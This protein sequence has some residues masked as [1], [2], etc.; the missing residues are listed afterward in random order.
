METEEQLNEQFNVK[1]TKKKGLIIGLAVAAA[2][3]VALVLVYFLALSN[4]KF[5]F[6][7]TIDKLFKVNTETYETIKIETSIKASADLEDVDYQEYA[8]E[9][10]KCTLKL[11]T[12]M[13]AEEKQE[14]VDLGLDYNKE[15]V[16]D[17][18]IYYND[19]EVYAYLDGLFDKYI[20]IDID[21]EAKATLEEVFESATSKENLKNTEKAAEIL[22]DEVKS[23]LKENGE[24]EKKKEKIEIGKDEEKVTKSTVTISEKQ[25]YK[26]F[27]NICTNLAK[28]DEFIECFE[29]SPKDLLKQAAD[30][31]KSL[32]GSNKNNVKISLYTKGLLNNKL[33]AVDVEIYS[34]DDAS[35]I[36]ASVVK[37]DEGM[38]SY[39]AYMKASRQKMELVNG[40]IEIEKDKNNKKEKSGKV[41]ITAD[42]IELGSAKLEIDYVV[43]YNQGIDK[44]NTK[45]SININSLTETDMQSIMAKLIERP[46]IK[47]LLED[48]MSNLGEN[49]TVEIP[50][51][52]GG[53]A[54]TTIP[55]QTTTAQ[56]EVKDYGYSVKYSV[57]T[58]FVYS[59][60][61]YDDM[62]FYDFEATDYS[63]IDATVTI[64]WNTETE[65][66]EGIKSDY[67]YWNTS[68]D[69]KNVA[70][71]DIKTIT[72]GDKQFKYQTLSYESNFG[73]GSES[74]YKD[75]Y[76]WYSL[77]DEYLYTVEL[78]GT[79]REIT[80][81]IMK[82]FLNI[83]VTKTN[84]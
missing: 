81:D 75:V 28:N 57:P 27:G 71:S 34:E 76:I 44:I 52:E 4:P 77:G 36:V 3:I 84:Y 11:G 7:K 62:K 74:K 19:G 43:N 73:Y 15:K 48:Q 58:G 46:L 16:V 26:I 37:E 22:R 53:T 66:L 56:D 21:E 40:K 54:N 35:T 38:Y 32:D 13:D 8:D 39:K 63:Y 14:I 72:V 12:Q 2:I 65:Y 9:I 82:E 59:Q 18:Q 30:E 47:D 24:F 17:A 50:T 78:D 67:E 45:N 69:Y 61:S 79:D 80:E 83:T 1:K 20:E 31:L 10:E 55:T 5:I 6:G 23:Q 42:V 49:T 33:V 51:I 29:E 68:T 60:Y 64:N 41:T 25:L 70:L